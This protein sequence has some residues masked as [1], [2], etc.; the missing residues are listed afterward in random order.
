MFV[1]TQ[2]RRRNVAALTLTLTTPT[3]M[4]PIPMG[5]AADKTF[6]GG[7]VSTYWTKLFLSVE[8][9]I[10]CPIKRKPSQASVETSMQ[11]WETLVKS[12][13]RFHCERIIQ[14]RIANIYGNSEC[15]SEIPVAVSIH[16]SIYLIYL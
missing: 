12:L 5:G 7:Y 15:G 4:G 6:P 11:I 13:L 9:C 16:L 14:T 3:T 8:I 2:R 10:S 1:V